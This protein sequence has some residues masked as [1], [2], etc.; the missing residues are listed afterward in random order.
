VSAIRASEIRYS[1]TAQYDGL[2]RLVCVDHLATQECGRG[3]YRALAK[4]RNVDLTLVVPPLWRENFRDVPVEP[5][6]PGSPFRLEILSILFAG[7]SNRCIHLGLGRLLR[8]I[9][10]DV[11]F[12]QS[13]PEDFLL[14]QVLVIRAI[15][16]LKFKIIFITWRN[17]HYPR[18]GI[19][20]KFGW[21][22]GFTEH[23][24]LRYADH[25][26]SFS[27]AGQEMLRARGFH[28]I[29]V[30]PPAIDTG[31]FKPTDGSAVRNTL[32]LQHFTIGYFGRFVNEKGVG[33]LLEAVAGLEYPIQLLMVG[34]GPARNTWMDLARQLKIEN[35]VVHQP[36]VLRSAMPSYICACDA[37][38]LPSY[39]TPQ[40][41]EQFGR[42]LI[43][44]MACG[45]P[46]VGA[47]SGEIPNVIGD[48]GLVFSEKN[49]P[50]L[51][52]CLRKLIE[53]PP[54]KQRLSSL[55]RA[56]A[57]NNYSCHVVAGTWLRAIRNLLISRE[58]FK[59]AP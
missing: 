43:E 19:P 21:V 7:K 42:V 32:R 11:V 24:G 38:V 2:L 23:F 12:L 33:L 20:Y 16:G 4:T 3:L 41:K 17:I 59:K 56:R 5:L 49:V 22:Y 31:F 6:S 58:G 29:D 26:F 40:W 27:A 55:G 47:R 9:R 48:A 36:S 13:E 53:N 52:G 25:C 35:M 1:T 45:V 28:T 54:L 37:V 51:R 18:F 30:I 8:H 39:A 44:A 15:Y 46:V 10:P 14:S 57:E 50:D 34:N